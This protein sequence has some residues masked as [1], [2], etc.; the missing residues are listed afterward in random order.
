LNTESSSV[1]VNGN[2]ETRSGPTP[3]PPGIKK[4]GDS[5]RIAI[6]FLIF[7]IIC[8]L[9]LILFLL[10]VLLRKNNKQKVLPNNFRFPKFL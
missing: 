9:I 1:Y 10:L 3:P 6:G 8:G 2:H 7:L 4:D 5:E